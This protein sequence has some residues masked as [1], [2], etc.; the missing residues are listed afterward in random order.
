MNLNLNPNAVEFALIAAA[1]V[2]FGYSWYTL[3]EAKKDAIANERLKINGARKVMSSIGVDVGWIN[4][5]CS[6]LILLGGLGALVFPPPPPD[7]TDMPQ[8][9]LLIVILILICLLLSLESQIMKSGR[10]RIDAQTPQSHQVTGS[11]SPSPDDVAA[12]E[13]AAGLTEVV[14]VNVER[15]IVVGA[16]P[17]GAEETAQA[18]KAVADAAVEAASAAKAVHRVARVVA[19]QAHKDADTAEKAEKAE[20]AKKE[21]S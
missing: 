12:A 10:R 11:V 9:L 6:S 4:L 20:D 21:E 16:V 17:V 18:A 2:F 3:R 14:N 13:K 5:I 1:A 7:Y 15:R 8:S 19:D